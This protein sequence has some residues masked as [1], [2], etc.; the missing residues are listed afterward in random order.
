MSGRDFLAGFDASFHSYSSDSLDPL[1]SIAVLITQFYETN[2]IAY[3]YTKGTKLFFGSFDLVDIDSF[4]KRTELLKNLLCWAGTSIEESALE[5]DYFCT[6]I[7]LLAGE[8]LEFQNVADVFDVS[9]RFIG[10][11]KVISLPEGLYILKFK[12]KGSKTVKLIVIGKRQ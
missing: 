2:G 7:I 3:E 1:G 10:A 12:H 6:S 8:K 5:R 9:G 11:Y 4:S